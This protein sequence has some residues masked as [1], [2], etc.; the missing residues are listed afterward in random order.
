MLHA[1]AKKTFEISK[2]KFI[3]KIVALLAPL[4]AAKCICMSAGPDA[5]YISK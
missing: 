4:I 5:K 3:H 1:I 2:E